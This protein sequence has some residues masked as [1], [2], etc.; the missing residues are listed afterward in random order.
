[1]SAFVG[2]HARFASDGRHMVVSVVHLYAK[3]VS[4]LVW[5]GLAGRLVGAV[6]TRARMFGHH[7][8]AELLPDGR[9][10]WADGAVVRVG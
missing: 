8:R 2:V 3:V 6:H 9:L 1:M 5:D 10:V 7:A 4:H